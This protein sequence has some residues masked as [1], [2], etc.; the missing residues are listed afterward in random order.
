VSARFGRSDRVRGGG[1]LL[2]AALVGAAVTVVGWTAGSFV[3]LGCGTALTLAATV[4][5][6]PRVWRWLEPQL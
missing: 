2:S 4:V 1:L 5:L 3:L 6:W